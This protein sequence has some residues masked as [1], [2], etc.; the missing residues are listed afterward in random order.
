M[1][2]HSLEHF[3]STDFGGDI[4]LRVEGVFSQ[5][6]DSREDETE[7]LVPVHLKACHTLLNRNKTYI[8][9]EVMENALPSIKN[10]P[11]L[12]DIIQRDDG[13]YDFRS[14]DFQIVDDPWHEGE[15]RV[16]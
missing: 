9:E 14:H 2:R 12:A 5:T 8:S 7:G 6:V 15:K 3:S 1:R 4:L 11:I 16:E 13:K 10:R